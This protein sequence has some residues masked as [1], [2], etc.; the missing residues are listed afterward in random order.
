ME[1]ITIANYL[2]AAGFLCSSTPTQN[3]ITSL[4]L[5]ESDKSVI[6][7]LPDDEGKEK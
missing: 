2:N 6:I 7:S 5:A 3:V 4:Q 1:D